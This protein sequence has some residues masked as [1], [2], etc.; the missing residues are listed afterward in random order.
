MTTHLTQRSRLRATSTA[1]SRSLSAAVGKRRDDVA[2]KLA[3]GNLEGGDRAQR[4]FLEEQRH[5]RATE[6]VRPSALSCPVARSRLTLRGQRKTGLELGGLEIEHREE[7]LG[8][9]G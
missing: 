4:R 3:H 1:G 5:V 8:A 6:R 2:A 9:N 7:V